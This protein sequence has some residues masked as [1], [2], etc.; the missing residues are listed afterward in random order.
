MFFILSKIIGLLINPVIWILALLFL[1]LFAKNTKLK[2]KFYLSSIILLLVFS[3]SFIL[4]EVL[5]KWELNSVKN[6]ELQES[7]DYGIVLS[8]MIWYD[9]ETERINF[10]QSSDR[11][12][13][14]VRLYNE[15]KIKKILISGGAAGFFEKDTIESVLLKQFLLK[16]GI[17]S[18]DILTEEQSRNT[19]ENAVFT[20]ELLQNHPHKKLLL[21]TSASHMRRARRCFEKVGLQCDI[22]PTDHYSG[23]RKYNFDHLFVPNARTLFNWNAFIHEIFGVVSYKFLGYI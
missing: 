18:N 16:I 14:A 2:R 7:Y 23:S 8:G 3:N 12:W 11:I 20:Y 17:E 4:N 22:F 9:S 19:R 6:S 10:L 15:G 21:I 5:L 13:Q 1:G